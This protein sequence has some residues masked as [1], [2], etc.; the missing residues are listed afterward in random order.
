MSLLIYKLTLKNINQANNPNTPPEV[1]AQL[2]KNKDYYVR[3]EV[4]KNSNTPS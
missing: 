2:A 1:L 3:M 4:A